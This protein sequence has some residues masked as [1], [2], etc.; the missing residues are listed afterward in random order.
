M[1]P[2]R[3]E[4]AAELLHSEIRGGNMRSA[5][6]LV[7]R[8][9]KI[10]LHRGFGRLSS[11]PD[12]P[13][14]APDSIYQVASITKPVTALALMKLVERGQLSLSD[15][16]SLHLPEFAGQDRAKTRVI[17]LLT[18]TSGLPDML[19]ENTD[20]RRQHAP[21]KEFVRRAMTTPLSFAPG[22]DFQ[23]QS[24]G[25]LLAAEIVERIS[26]LTLPEFERKEIFHPLRMRHSV[27]G[28][29]PLRIADT[30]QMQEASNA[31]SAD[32]TSFGGNSEYWRRMGHP[33]GGMHTSTTELAILLQTFLNGGT[34]A[35][36]RIISPATARTM[37]TDQ[38]G[39]LGKPW[40]L[41]WGLARSTVWSKFGDLVS[42]ETFGHSGASG[43]VAW[44]DPQSQVICVILTG[45]PSAWDD[46][47]LLRRVSNAVAA[48]VEK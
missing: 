26:G 18:H 47:R 5:S 12:A 36:Q 9:G 4:R 27:L 14:V 2:A 41:G 15:P 10:V 25:I 28:L 31:D 39:R 34:Y 35:G 24:M 8:Q 20:L 22:T 3:L 7:A 48:A 40:G 32:R 11:Q 42:P 21:L 1:S 29:E 33:W 43:T 38:N 19:P 46:G 17:D 13:A 44:A 16:V 23:Y 37:V 6:I 45:R 30:V